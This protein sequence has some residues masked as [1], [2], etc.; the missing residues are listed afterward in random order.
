MSST[1]QAGDSIVVEI[2]NVYKFEILKKQS[3][4]SENIGISNRFHLPSGNNLFFSHNL[5]KDIE[6]DLLGFLRKLFI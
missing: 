4:P 6:T 1:P 5:A 2:D 3:L